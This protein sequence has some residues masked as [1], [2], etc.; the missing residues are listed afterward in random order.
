MRAVG[1]GARSVAGES[2][3][4]TGEEPARPATY[5]PSTAADGPSA[6]FGSFEVDEAKPARRAVVGWLALAAVIGVLVAVSLWSNGSEPAASSADIHQGDCLVSSSGQAVALVDCGSPDVE[7]SVA[8]RYESSTD[9]ARCA[10]V[11]SDLVLVT[12]DE[13]VLC[14]NYRAKVGECLFA[15]V[16]EEVGKAPCRTPGTSTP[17]GLYRVIAVLPDSVD[18]RKCPTGTVESLVHITS[19]EVVC[20]G[21]P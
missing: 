9:S 4:G 14:L 6:V 16:A 11:S 12:H 18:A 5:P 1:P 8:A 3:R 13:A 20:L 15:G 7:F 2:H 10:A 19:R 21:L 17:I